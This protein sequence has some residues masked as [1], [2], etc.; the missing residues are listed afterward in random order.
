MS[1]SVIISNKKI[2]G[3]EQ[4]VVTQPKDAVPLS[5][6]QDLSAVVY[7]LSGYVYS[8][9]L[10]DVLTVGNDAGG[11]SEYNKFSNDVALTTING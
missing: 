1:Y 3:L 2:T 4:A 8:I 10:N 11:L 5:M 9:D 7:D 6:L